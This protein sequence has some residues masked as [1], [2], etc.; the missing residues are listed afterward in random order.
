MFYQFSTTHRILIINLETFLTVSGT[1]QY[2]FFCCCHFFMF[3]SYLQIQASVYSIYASF[4][5]PLHCFWNWSYL[6]NPLKLLNQLNSASGITGRCRTHRII[7]VCVKG[8]FR[9]YEVPSYL[10]MLLHSDIWWDVIVTF[11]Y[12]Y[13]YIYYV[14]INSRHVITLN[15]L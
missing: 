10:I 14:M 1:L 8:K 4:C 7:L 13:I 12:I 3:I 15:L 9:L 6:N 5:K 2:P 11:I